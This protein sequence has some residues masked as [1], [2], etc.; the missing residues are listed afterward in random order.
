MFE[1]LKKNEK[2]TRKF[3]MPEGLS[4]EEQKQIK[5]IIKQAKKDDGMP[6]TAQQSIPFDRMF[7]DGICRVGQDY[8]TKTIQFQDINYQLAL[9]EDKTEIFEEWCSFLNFF[10]SSISFELSFMNMLTD[11]HAFEKS[12]AIKHKKDKFNDVRDE[13]SGVLFHQMEAGNNG[14]TKTKFLTF[15][16]HADSMKVAKPRLLML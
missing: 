7:R 9:Q 5:T 10:D 12:I 13:Y 14:L 16:I 4:R 8:Y 3:I 2:P 15:G 1:F 6:R 11:A